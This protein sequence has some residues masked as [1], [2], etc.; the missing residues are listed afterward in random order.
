[1]LGTLEMISET[2]KDPPRHIKISKNTEKG[3]GNKGNQGPRRLAQYIGMRL[4]D[5]EKKFPGEIGK[6]CMDDTD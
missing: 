2:G 5:V 3:Q 1:M 6:F 4:K